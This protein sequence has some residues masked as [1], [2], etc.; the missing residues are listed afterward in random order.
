MVRPPPL[1]AADKTN[2]LDTF[3]STEPDAKAT[4]TRWME[5]SGISADKIA[6]EIANA[7]KQNTFLL[8]THPKTHSVWRLKRWFPGI[9]FKLLSKRMG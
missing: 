4:V 9:Y 2:L 5:S 1:Y 8:L 6:E 3:R 7:V